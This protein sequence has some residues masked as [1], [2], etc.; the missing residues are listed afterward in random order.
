MHQLAPACTGVSISPQRH[1]L[2]QGPLVCI[3]DV[4]R[5][6][7]SPV[8]GLQGESPLGQCFSHRVHKGL[9]LWVIIIKNMKKT[10][11]YIS[12]L[13][14]LSIVVLGLLLPTLKAYA[15]VRSSSIISSSVSRGILIG[16]GVGVGALVLISM[17]AIRVIRRKKHS[18]D[19]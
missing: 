4:V 15:D 11:N 9:F 19:K 6:S 16:V 2:A 1:H 10:T 8:S 14:A 5:R 17:L 18:I 13:T 3:T 12:M 7:G